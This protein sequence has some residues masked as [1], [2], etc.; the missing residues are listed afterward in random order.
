MTATHVHVGV[1]AERSVPPSFSLRG[2]IRLVAVEEV[3]SELPQ[4]LLR[5]LSLMAGNGCG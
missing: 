3:P 4:R 1:P 5:P 2:H